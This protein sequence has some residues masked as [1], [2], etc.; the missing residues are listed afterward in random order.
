M[1]FKSR[2]LVAEDDP[3]NL[4]VIMRTLRRLGY[5]AEVARNGRE[6]VQAACGS[7]FDIIFMDVMM[8]ELDGIEAAREIR[9]NPSAGEPIIV[10]LTANVMPEDRT[11]A[12]SAGMDDYL[13]KPIRLESVRAVLDKLIPRSPSELPVGGS[14]A[15][16][17]IL[18][19]STLEDLREMMGDDDYFKELVNDYILNAQSLV[20]E[21]TSGISAADWSVVR[22]AAHSLSATSATFGGKRLSEWARVLEDEALLAASE[23]GRTEDAET[24]DPPRSAELATDRLPRTLLELRRESDRMSDLLRRSV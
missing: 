17:D 11:A 23:G 5:E 4:L 21:M 10:A 2:I 9:A 19:R 15:S 16:A 20:D 24:Q 1:D 7:L 8:P 22:R 13:T 14:P 12:L 6:A 18:N 3:V